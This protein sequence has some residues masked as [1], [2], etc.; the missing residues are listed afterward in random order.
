MG[1]VTDGAGRP[2]GNSPISREAAPSCNPSIV[3]DIICQAQEDF[4]NTLVITVT[5]S[6]GTELH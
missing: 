4:L 5:L 1:N 2:Y 3:K 6:Y